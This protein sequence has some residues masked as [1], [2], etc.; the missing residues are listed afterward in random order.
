YTEIFQS[1][2]PKDAAEE[3]VEIREDGVYLITGGTGGMGIEMAKYLAADKPVNVALVNRTPLPDRKL[4]DDMTRKNNQT[5]C[6]L[7]E[8]IEAIREVEALGAVVE[9]YAADVANYEQMQTV[10]A[11]V[12]SRFGRINGIVHGAGVGGDGFLFVKDEQV[13]NEVVQPKVFGTWILDR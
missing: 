10:I 6:K 5:Y 8:R 9:Y 13:F 3:R 4:W 2:D 11:Q 12:R 1:Y 7:I